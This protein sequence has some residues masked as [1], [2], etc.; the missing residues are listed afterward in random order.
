MRMTAPFLRRRRVRLLLIAVG[1]AGV[2]IGIIGLALWIASPRLTPLIEGASFREMLDRQTS[3]GLHF[4]GHYE[5]IVRTGFASAWTSGFEADDGVK[6][7]KS[8]EAHNV[9]ARFN[10]WGV[11]LRR[12][13]FDFVHIARGVVDVQTYEPKP[14]P[15]EKRPWYAIFMPSR[16]HLSKVVCD[17]A[18]VKWE[19][20]GEEGG[21]FGTQL[22]ITPH[23]RD[24]EYRAK[25]GEMRNAGLMPTMDVTAIH[26]LITKKILEVYALELAVGERGTIRVTGKAGIGNDRHVSAG[27]TFEHVPLSPWLPADIRASVRGAATGA[28]QWRGTDQTIEASSGEGEIQVDGGELVDLPLLDYLATATGRRTLERVSLDRC[29]LKFHWEGERIDVE[30]V[31]LASEG[32]FGLR[33]NVSMGR[34]RALDGTLEL[35]MASSL[36]D[37]LPRAKEDIFTREADGLLWTTVRL[38]GTIDD[39][40][41]D[42]GPRLAEALRKDPAAATGLFFRGIG[43]WLKQKVRER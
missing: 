32:K 38:S 7:M 26:L 22:L 14:D 23:G 31:D 27:L 15:K 4:D 33:G 2:I 43:E 11:L 10:P 40:V 19:L 42:L 41:N 9:S 5:P 18:D 34:E 37:W 25:G 1:L 35:G 39:P 36:L 30:S 8:L 24:F 21:I 3:K 29:A 28:I 6:A 12:W 17:D 16:V 20:R 13:Q